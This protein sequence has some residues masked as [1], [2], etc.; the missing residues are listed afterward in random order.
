MGWFSGATTSAPSLVEAVSGPV[1]VITAP[2]AVDLMTTPPALTAAAPGKRVFDV[3]AGTVLLVVLL[4]VLA[5]IALL[6]S[7]TSRGSA[8]LVQE[9]V[10]RYGETFRMVKFRTMVRGADEWRAEVIGEPDDGIL[11]RYRTDPRI[12]PLGRVLRRWSLD[13]LPQLLNVVVG[14]M[15]LVGPR[16]LLPDEMTLLTPTD[17]RRHFVKPGIT[18]LWQVSGRKELGWDERMR[19]DQLYATSRTARMDLFILLRTFRAVLNGEGAM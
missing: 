15:S 10:G 14:S 12:T 7:L 13:E 17:H 9:R 2:P 3:V 16:P 4:P 19:L 8:V 6:I 1:S 11:D 5:L 18:G